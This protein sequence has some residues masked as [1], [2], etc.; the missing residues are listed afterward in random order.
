MAAIGAILTSILTLGNVQFFSRNH[1]YF[2]DFKNVEALPPKAA[3]KVAGVEIGKVRKVQLV[4]GRARVTIDIDPDVVVFEDATAQVDS[5]GII[6]TKFI[7]LKP[8]TPDLAELP[9]KSTIRG[10]EGVSLN[11]MLTK[12]SSL[13]ESDEKH[14]DAVNNFKETMANIRNITRALNQAMGSHGTEMEEIVMN[15]RDLTASIKVF[16]AH[17]EEISTE[18][19]EDFKMA[20]EKFRGVGEKL[21]TLLAKINRGEGAIGALLNDK[22]TEK[23]VKETVASAKKFLG[24][25]SSIH[26]YWDYRYRYDFRDDEGRSDVAVKFVPSPGKFYAVGATNIGEMPNDEKHTAFERKN[27]I[28]AVMG[29]DYGP[30]TGYAGAI[31]SS[32]GVGLNFRP[33]FWLPKLNRRFEITSEV[34]DFSRDRNVKGHHLDSALLNVGAHM[35]ITRWLWV[36]ARA[37]DLYERTSYQAYMNI[38]FRD[39]DLAYLLGLASAAR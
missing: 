14:G 28:T 32:G 5:T 26:T 25:F 6:G 27:R 35:A 36:G 34:S 30:F 12:L 37:E 10:V 33:F 3:V 38:I 16:S 1:R 15:V 29:H 20:I 2:V 22:Q 21:D 11:Q 9:S 24:K 17:L 4:E 19:K 18:K 31:R 13:F 7:E 23:D 39:T 8:G